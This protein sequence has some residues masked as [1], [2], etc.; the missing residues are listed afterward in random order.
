MQRF[1]LN[2]PALITIMDESGNQ[3]ALEVMIRNICAGGSYFKT[4]EPLS[5]GT[6]VKMDL[7]LAFD[8]LKENLINEWISF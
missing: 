7:I 5:V 4:D 8:K 3:K 1:S 2:L 6:D